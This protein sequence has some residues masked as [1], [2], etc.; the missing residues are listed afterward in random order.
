[1]NRIDCCQRIFYLLISSHNFYLPGAWMEI[2][3]N[4]HC[5]YNSMQGEF[6]TKLAYSALIHDHSEA[7]ITFWKLKDLCFSLVTCSWHAVN[8]KQLQEVGNYG[9][10]FVW[11]MWW[12]WEPPSHYVRLQL[13]E[14][15]LLG[16]IKS[17]IKFVDIQETCRIKIKPN[18][19]TI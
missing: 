6:S 3:S 15:L 10:W 8:E 16:Q 13:G 14:A 19:R 11:S 4:C 17:S 5:W 18:H 7:L 9:G 12:N 1:M 2:G